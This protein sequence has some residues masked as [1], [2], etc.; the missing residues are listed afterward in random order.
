ML[1]LID[2]HNLIAKMPNIC[3]DEADDEE[4]LILSLRRYRARTGREVTVF[5]DAGL[6]FNLANKRTYGGLTVHYAPQGTPADNLIV[7]QLY[8]IKNPQQTLVVSSDRAIQRAARR[9][10]AEIIS[11]ADFALVLT[12]AEDDEPDSED[13]VALSEDEVEAWL[14]LFNQ[15]G[16]GL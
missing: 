4:K 11:S 2:G 8:R 1:V 12:P 9:V 6:S 15:K 14:R 16:G 13:D 5:F 3:L 10:G 7:R